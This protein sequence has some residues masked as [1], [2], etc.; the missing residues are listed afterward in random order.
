LAGESW[1]GRS[2]QCAPPPLRAEL[3][4]ARASSTNGTGGAG[5]GFFFFG[6]CPIL[7]SA[8]NSIDA[9]GSPSHAS[10]NAS[11]PAPPSS[12]LS[13]HSSGSIRWAN[14]TLLRDNNPEDH[15]GSSSLYLAPPPQGHRRKSSIATVSSVG[16]SST[17][18]DMEDNVS[19]R[20]SPLRS[21]CSDVTSTLPSPTQTPVDAN[22]DAGSRPPSVNC[23]IRRTMHRQHRVRRPSPSPSGETDTASDTT[24]IWMSVPLPSNNFSSRVLWTRKV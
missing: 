20:L 5:G 10:D 7:R 13:A 4:Q 2:C 3:S 24:L 12:T 16:S 17:D 6:E 1:R 19:F 14:S 18:R 23:F 9:F 15:D 22:S 8:R 11:L 21:A